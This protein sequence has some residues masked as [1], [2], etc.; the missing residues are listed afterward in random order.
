MKSSKAKEFPHVVKK[1]IFKCFEAQIN[2]HNNLNEIK[3]SVSVY[4]CKINSDQNTHRHF[5]QAMS[6][7]WRLKRK[8]N[9]FYKFRF[10]CAVFFSVCALTGFI[11]FIQGAI[12]WIL[13]KFLLIYI[14]F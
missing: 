14:F 12:A 3:L 11:D 9:W 10:F 6:S 7:S 13:E 8:H 4:S 1:K 2:F 5:L